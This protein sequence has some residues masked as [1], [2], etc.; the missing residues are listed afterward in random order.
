MGPRTL[1]YLRRILE[2]HVLT[3]SIATVRLGKLKR[4]HILDFRERLI[5]KLGYTRTVQKAVGVLKTILK[6][7]FFR[8]DISRDP[9]V[10][11]GVSRYQPKEI[12][13]FTAEELKTLF[14][15]KPP[16]PWGDLTGYAVFLTAAT[17]GMRR[18]EIL[19]LPYVFFHYSYVGS[20]TDVLD[21]WKLYARWGDDSQGNV[22]ALDA[23][24]LLDKD[25]RGLFTLKA[26]HPPAA[27][28]SIQRVKQRH[29]AP[30][31][32]FQALIEVHEREVSIQK[33]SRL[34][35]LLN[36]RQ[37]QFFLRLRAYL[38]FLGHGEAARPWTAV[39]PTT[40]TLQAYGAIVRV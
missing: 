39:T 37:R 9:T 31:R 1:P 8:E 12:G 6:E 15:E 38:K 16:G 20:T 26:P 35:Q 36:F 25:S 21:K 29:E 2:N 7:A 23:A 24:T 13:V 17:T 40:P 30:Y 14:P 22:N 5:E 27:M 3:D 11:I 19:A 32:R 28:E 33:A 34:L 4:S 18:G 10:G